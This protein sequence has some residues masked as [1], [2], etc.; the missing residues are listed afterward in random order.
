MDTR[1][2]KIGHEAESIGPRQR[3]YQDIVS[4][5]NEHW[6]PND[7]KTIE[8]MQALDRE[9]GSLSKKRDA[10]IVCGTN[11]KSLTLHFTTK[12]LEA[13]GLKVGT[14]FAPHILT[15]NERFVVNKATV[16]NKTF[17]DLGNLVLDAAERLKIKIT[18]NELLT[19]MALLFF[20]E[21]KCDVVLCESNEG[22][23]YNPVNICHAKVVAITRV[24]P[25]GIEVSPEELRELLCS[26][27]GT[28]KQGTHLISGDQVKAHLQ[29]MEDMAAAQ[30]AQWAMPIRKLA[31]LAYPFEQLHGRCAALAERIAHLYVN[32]VIAREA[33]IVKDSLLVKQNGRRGRPTIEAKRLAKLNPKK[34]IEQ[35]W[36]EAT[37][38]LPGR[39]QLLDKEKPSVL[40]D[41]ADN[42]DALE[43][44]LLGIR[45]LHYQRPLKGLTV[46]LGAG[47]HALLNEDFLKALRY[48]FKKTSGQ[49]F[50]CPVTNENTPGNGE[51]E[52]WNCEQVASDLK[53]KKVKA[54]AFNSFAEAF[55]VAKNTVDERYG[56][57]VITGSNAILNEFWRVKGMKKL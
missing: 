2:R 50:V 21:Q 55:E 28:V 41:S 20:E 7:S 43:N 14:F 4:F 49:V 16:Q 47:K 25:T 42:L 56:L 15:Y 31:P 9:L 53:N 24:T 37:N 46:I 22:G 17:T 8:R 44:L 45:L 57:V 39:F 30:N 26:M 52:S 18:S 32:N 51:A 54:T 12:L 13:E 6:Q 40:L 38:E 1:N 3:S 36:K 10:I 19:L 48:F 5:L 35:F 27:M 33:I 34:T 23:K 11:G 29:M